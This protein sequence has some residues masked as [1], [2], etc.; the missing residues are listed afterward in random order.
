MKLNFLDESCLEIGFMRNSPS[1]GDCNQ[2][3]N[4]KSSFL[5]FSFLYDRKQLMKLFEIERRHSSRNDLVKVVMSALRLLWDIQELISQVCGFETFSLNF[6]HFRSHVFPVVAENHVDLG[7]SWT[8][9]PSHSGVRRRIS[10]DRSSWVPRQLMSL[11]LYLPC[12][13]IG[14]FL[15]NNGLLEAHFPVFFEH[16]SVFLRSPVSI[17]PVALHKVVH[18]VFSPSQHESWGFM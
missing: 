6:D 5:S 16:Y 13:A 14:E 8:E 17:R 1:L 15:G 11:I 4:D 7:T 9:L 10:L 2:Q 12:R 18:D 3:I